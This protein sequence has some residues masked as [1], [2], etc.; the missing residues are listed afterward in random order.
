MNHEPFREADD[1][2]FN[3]IHVMATKF[4][5]MNTGKSNYKNR[6]TYLS[7]DSDALF[8]TLTGIAVKRS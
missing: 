8:V 1:E 2:R 5:E 4:Q 3:Y 6:V 7:T